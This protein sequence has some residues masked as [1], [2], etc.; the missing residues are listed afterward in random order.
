MEGIAATIEGTVI[1][2]SGLYIV[3]EA[4]NKII[5][6]EKISYINWTL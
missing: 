1:I 3:Y 4:I 2:L 6:P 5:S